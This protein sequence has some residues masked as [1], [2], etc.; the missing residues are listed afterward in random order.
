MFIPTARM[1]R[2]AHTC[3]DTGPAMKPCVPTVCPAGVSPL[4]P[5]PRVSKTCGRR[6]RALPGQR[7]IA[8]VSIYS[9][10][11]YEGPRLLT[12]GGLDLDDVG[13]LRVLAC[14]DS[15][16]GLH[17]EYVLLAGRQAVHHK[18]EQN[19]SQGHD[20]APQPFPFSFSRVKIMG[21]VQ[22]FFSL[23]LKG[24]RVV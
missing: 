12:E 4:L 10:R 23:G 16:D 19:T 1:S 6:M 7:V 5:Q 8:T 14:A 24:T 11:A 2:W 15:V 21:I 3:R 17:P 18:P 22:K 13:L 20:H 9:R